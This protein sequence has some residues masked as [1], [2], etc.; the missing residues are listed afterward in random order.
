MFTYIKLKNFL[1]LGD[2]VF[3]FRKTKTDITHLAI[4]YGEN[5]SGKTNFI[6]AFSFLF[7]S[8]HSFAYQ[9]NYEKLVS[10][11]RENDEQINDILRTLSLFSDF[12]EYMSEHRM[13]DCDEPTEVE[14]GFMMNER[15]A[16]YRLSF[17]DHIIEESLYCFTGKQRG[18]LFQFTSDS[19]GEIK[20]KMQPEL[21]RQTAYKKEI[22]EKVNQYWGKHSFLSIITNQ[23]NDKNSKYVKENISP[24][25][26]DALKQLKNLFITSKLSQGNERHV[27]FN[28]TDNIL[29]NLDAGTVS[30]SEIPIIQRTEE[31]LRDFFTQTYADIKDVEYE[32]TN[33]EDDKCKYQLYI[34]K[35]ICGKIRKISFAKESAGTQQVLRIIRSLIGLFFGVTVVYDEIDN[36]VH[37]I[38][39]TQ[40]IKSLQN[41]IT[42][43]LIITTHN[44]MLL[45]E[46]DPHSVYVISTD[47]LGNKD[48]HCAAEYAVQ[49]N[50]NLRARY[51]KGLFGGIPY[52]EGI[53][54]DAIEHFLAEGGKASWQE[55]QE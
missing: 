31:I 45:E 32:L 13:I 25:F 9:H 2:V 14:Y 34:D 17:T 28:E 50:H 36:G 19:N 37:D 52:V 48:V 29:Q 24:Y 39:L 20:T 12:S 6:Q 35:M 53:N 49:T 42:G 27:R 10:A 11:F 54:F 8:V 38:L 5:G 40:I 44:T 55:K 30:S 51:L 16:V 18:Y 33:L 3:D 21:V 41:E 23:S 4:V 15:E 46:M 1:S 7:N 47:Y 22:I 43:Q 26:L